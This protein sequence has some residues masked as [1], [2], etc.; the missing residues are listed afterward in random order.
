MS[1]Q[2]IDGKAIAEK[3]KIDIKNQ[4]NVLNRQN[5]IPGLATVLVGTDPASEIYV[6]NKHRACEKVGIVSFHHTLPEETTTE[7]LLQ[8]IRELNQDNRIHGILV[9][10]P[11]PAH[12]SSKSVLLAI[13]PKKDVDGFHPYNLGRLFAAKNWNELESMHPT[14]P[15]PCT[16]YGAMILLEK[17]GISL[18]GKNAVVLGRS[19]IVGKPM[20]ALLLSKH[21]TVSVVHS[22]TKNLLHYCKKADILVVAVGKPKQVTGEMLQRESVVIDVGINRKENGKICGDVDFDSAKE[23]TGWITPVPGGV[24]P[25]TITMLLKNTVRLAQNHSCG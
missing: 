13:D 9:Q 6:K 14:L 24:G 8:K 12:I 18:A 15:I 1:A 20:A 7:K 22:H 25:M 16:P 11:L 17:I 2:L 19:T 21:A 10:L 4:V 3:L 5:V 23:V